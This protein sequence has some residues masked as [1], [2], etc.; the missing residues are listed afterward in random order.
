MIEAKHCAISFS[1]V[2]ISLWVCE[3]LFMSFP[4][5]IAMLT[6]FPCASPQVRFLNIFHFGP[7]ID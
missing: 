6:A 3:G 4:N 2:H 7:C 1:T 5:T